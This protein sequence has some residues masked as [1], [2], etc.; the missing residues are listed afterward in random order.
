M[1]KFYVYVHTVY[2]Y[3]SSRSSAV[4]RKCQQ[5]KLFLS[6]SSGFWSR[7]DSSIDANVSERHTVSI[8][9]AEIIF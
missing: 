4:F 3:G 1:H 6:C 8:F 7:A 9:R 2:I 5:I